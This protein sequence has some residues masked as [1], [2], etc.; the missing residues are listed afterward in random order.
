MLNHLI[1][2]PLKF[3]VDF[4]RKVWLHALATQG[5]VRYGSTQSWVKLYQVSHSDDGSTFQVVCESLTTNPKVGAIWLRSMRKSLVVFVRPSTFE[6][7][8]PLK[9]SFHFCIQKVSLTVGIFNLRATLYQGI[10]LLC[11]LQAFVNPLYGQY[12]T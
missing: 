3:Q 10:S 12:L 8:S 1:G 9:N 2:I 6:S 11:S 4:G 7:S 5:H